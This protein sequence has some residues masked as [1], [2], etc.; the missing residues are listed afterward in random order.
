MIQHS[1][2][3]CP[4]KFCWCIFKIVLNI[5]QIVYKCAA[6]CKIVPSL[7]NGVCTLVHLN[8]RAPGDSGHIKPIDQFCPHTSQHSFC[9]TLDGF[10]DLCTKRC[11][12]IHRIYVNMCFTHSHRKISKVVMSGEHGARRLA[13]HLIFMSWVISATWLWMKKMKEKIKWLKKRGTLMKMPSS[14]TCVAG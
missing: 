12:I 14:I 3:V 11:S 10:I 6:V 7:K 1:D 8:N 4:Q 9:H 5:N 2:T 13:C